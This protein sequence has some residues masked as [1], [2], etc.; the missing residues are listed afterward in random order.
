MSK[1]VLGL[2]ASVYRNG[3]GDCSNG[4][5]SY[6]HDEAVITGYKI[7][8]D[9]EVFSPSESAPHYVIIKDFVNGGQPRLRAIPADLLESGKWTM[10][11]GNFLYTSDSRF[12]SDAPIKIHDRVEG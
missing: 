1:A 10:F 3:R 11:G 12:P 2:S 5:A 7:N 9:C 4:G 8:S 6:L